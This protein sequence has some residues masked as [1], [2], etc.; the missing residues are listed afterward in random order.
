LG[1]G[2]AGSCVLDAAR[3]AGRGGAIGGRAAPGFRALDLLAS[4]R[5]VGSVFDF[6]GRAAGRATGRSRPVGADSED[7]PAGREG[8]GA[9]PAPARAGPRGGFADSSRYG[10]SS[11]ERGKLALCW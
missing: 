8:R 1:L 11:D 6:A 5:G 4:G 2:E 10:E 7:R 3:C 9:R